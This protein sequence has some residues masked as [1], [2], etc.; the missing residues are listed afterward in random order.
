M[1]ECT[2]RF[3][4]RTQ[5]EIFHW[6]ILIISQAYSNFRFWHRFC[7][8]DN[9]SCVPCCD[10]CKTYSVRVCVRHLLFQGVIVPLSCQVTKCLAAVS[11]NTWGVFNHPALP[12][13]F[14]TDGSL[15]T[16]DHVEV[17]I[18]NVPIPPLSHLSSKPFD[19]SNYFPVS[20]PSQV[21]L[22]FYLND[23]SKHPSPAS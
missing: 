10:I 3:V 22:L 2:F 14:S 19:F 6:C 12:L 20:N 15:P 18:S 21:A 13:F 17:Q 23:N 1:N 16:I 9:S 4:W 8:I 7:S 11:N 5:I